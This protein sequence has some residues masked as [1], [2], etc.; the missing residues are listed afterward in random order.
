[1]NGNPHVWLKSLIDGGEGRHKKVPNESSSM[2]HLHDLA[3]L[4]LAAYEN[5]NAYMVIISGAWQYN[6]GLMK[7]KIT[8]CIK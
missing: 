6:I 8:I 5:H 3:A 4:F 7:V 2:I 1:M